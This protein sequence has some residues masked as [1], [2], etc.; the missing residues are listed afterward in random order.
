MNVQDAI[1]IVQATV[2]SNTENIGQLTEI[3][4][5]CEETEAT[6]AEYL[7][8]GNEEVG[9]LGAA[10]NQANAALSLAYAA[11]VEMEHL[12]EILASIL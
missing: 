2:E 8:A 12:G 5:F 1:G 11:Q 6:L 3:K 7:G 4:T 9:K 10:S